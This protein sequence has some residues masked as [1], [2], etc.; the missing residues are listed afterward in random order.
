MMYFIPWAVFLLLVVASL[1]IAALLEKRK[2]Q[3]A[4]GGTEEIGDEFGDEP[5]IDEGEESFAEEAGEPVEFAEDDAFGGDA[6]DAFG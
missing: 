3:A 6:D 2:M 1:P 5:V 4:Y